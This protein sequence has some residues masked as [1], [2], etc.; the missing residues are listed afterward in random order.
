[1]KFLRGDVQQFDESIRQFVHRFASPG[2]TSTM[3]I[4]TMLGSSLVLL[5]FAFAIGLCLIRA[6]QI[7]AAFFLAV[8]M[9]GSILLE[10]VL[11]WSFRRPRPPP[12]FGTLPDSYSFPSGHALMAF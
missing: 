12:F 6:K 2:I 7:R 1:M 3:Q 5:A 9:S 10:L 4:M 8:T 11:K